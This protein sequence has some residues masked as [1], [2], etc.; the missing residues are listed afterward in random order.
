MSDNIVE[1]QLDISYSNVDD[2]LS[3]CMV[4]NEDGNQ[5]FKKT[6]KKYIAMLNK[7][8]NVLTLVKDSVDDDEL[9]GVELKS[10]CDKLIIR[11]SQEIVDRFIGF[12]IANYETDSDD[13]GS[14]DDNS[15][16]EEETENYM[17]SSSEEEEEDD[18]NK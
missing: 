8:I 10:N 18:E 16:L 6:L 1:A 9:E 14:L 7:A 2:D 11:G 12:G 15:S 4:S 13:Y 3:S 5:N 17:P